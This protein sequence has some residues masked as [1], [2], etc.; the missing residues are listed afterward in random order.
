MHAKSLQSCSTL[1]FVILWTRSLPGS[2]HETLQARTLSELPC[3][4]PDIFPTQGSNLS[5]C[6]ILNWQAC[7]TYQHHL[8]STFN[9]GPQ[10]RSPLCMSLA[11]VIRC[12]YKEIETISPLSSIWTG[13]VTCLANRKWWTLQNSGVQVLRG[14]AAS[15]LFL[16]LNPCY[17]ECYCS[18]CSCHEEA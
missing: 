11:V 5:L 17:G 8:G 6:N 13:F 14:L 15:A 1:F 10:N 12:F 4:P 7:F 18:V 9:I 16:C 2:V 3:L